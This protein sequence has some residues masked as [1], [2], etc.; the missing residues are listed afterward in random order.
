MEFSGKRPTLVSTDSSSPVLAG[1]LVLV[2]VVR[3]D[4]SDELG[5]FSLVLRL[6]FSESEL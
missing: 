1:L 2:S 3:L 5:E 6:D 4:G